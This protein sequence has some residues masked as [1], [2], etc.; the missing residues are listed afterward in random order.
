MPRG[1]R[2]A[3]VAVM[4]AAWIFAVLFACRS[5]TRAE[6]QPVPSATVVA[7]AAV[8]SVPLVLLEKPDGSLPEGRIQARHIVIAWAGARG[9]KQTRTKEEARKRADDLLAKL[10]GGADFAVVA[11]E[12]SEDATAPRGGDLGVFA[13]TDLI[14]PIADA[15]F[16]LSPL[17]ISPIIETDQGFHIIQ[18]V[19]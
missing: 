9:A 4:R 5:G 3:T 8:A 11:T 6:A 16:A 13:R 18:R 10:R 12:S 14:A 17:E 1:G 2:A 15:A 19:R 7:T